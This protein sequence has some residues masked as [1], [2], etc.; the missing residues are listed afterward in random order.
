ME[1]DAPIVEVRNGNVVNHRLGQRKAHSRH[2]GQVQL[3]ET[4][5]SSPSS[6]GGN[7]HWGSSRSSQQSTM[8]R[9][10]GESNQPARP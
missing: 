5:D 1:E 10:S 9:V 7:S 6:G 8:M 3:L 2:T 4:P